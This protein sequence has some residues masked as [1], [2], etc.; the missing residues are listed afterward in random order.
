[1]LGFLCILTKCRSPSDLAWATV[2]SLWSCVCLPS[3]AAAENGARDAEALFESKV[4]PLLVAKCQECHGATIAEADVPWTGPGGWRT[5]RRC[6][7][8]SMLPWKTPSTLI[9]IS[10]TMTYAIR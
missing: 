8:M 10:S 6:R 2:A 5:Q 4:R 1:M 9:R 3:A 7:S